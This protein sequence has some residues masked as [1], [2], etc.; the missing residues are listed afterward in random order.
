MALK[1]F[2]AL[3]PRDVPRWPHPNPNDTIAE[4]ADA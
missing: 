3:N 2:L 1:P 4:F